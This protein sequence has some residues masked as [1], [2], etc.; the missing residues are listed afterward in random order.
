MLQD[1]QRIS[2]DFASRS[3]DSLNLLQGFSRREFTLRTEW[4]QSVQRIIDSW[5]FGFG[6]PAVAG[7]LESY[8]QDGNG[9]TVD[10]S[11]HHNI[12]A[13]IPDFARVLQT[14][15]LQDVREFCQTIIQDLKVRLSHN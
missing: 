14:C 4:A 9:T 12:R 6:S 10:T 5:Y 8:S 2:L 11:M 3:V 1:L 7:F 13:Q 15:P